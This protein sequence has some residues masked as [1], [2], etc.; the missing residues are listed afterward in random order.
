MNERLTK[1]TPVIIT[2]DDFNRLVRFVEEF[3]KKHLELAKEYRQRS[4][5]W[6][7]MF[8]FIDGKVAGGKLSDGEA[9]LLKASTTA[10]EEVLGAHDSL[11]KLLA[12]GVW[13]KRFEEIVAY[14]GRHGV[15]V[16]AMLVDAD[17]LKKIN[18]RLGHNKGDKVLIEIA[19]AIKEGIRMEDIAGRFGGDEFTVGCVNCELGGAKEIAQRITA[20]L[21]GE[22]T[23]SIGVGQIGVQETPTKFIQRIDKAMYD[24]KE[25]KKLGVSQIVVSYLKRVSKQSK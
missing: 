6:G 23:V 1:E 12:K 22:V 7:A 14:G 17:D 3:P 16:S 24:A 18:D 4:K 13:E 10:A 21:S 25:Q 2:E 15:P 19:R 5:F 8:A 9:S 20:G 11:T